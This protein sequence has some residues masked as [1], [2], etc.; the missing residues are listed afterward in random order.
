MN[1]LWCVFRDHRGKITYINDYTAPQSIVSNMRA[2]TK[3]AGS[4]TKEII[5]AGLSR[6][7]LKGFLVL[8][9]RFLMVRAAFMFCSI[10][11]LS[12]LL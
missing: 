7:S 1:V 10:L 3:Q 4:C 6:M 5:T 12:A 8:S 2:C 11:S 9:Y